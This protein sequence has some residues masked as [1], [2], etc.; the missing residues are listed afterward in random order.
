MN[1]V[2][3][4]EM[5]RYNV[6]IVA[7]RQSLSDMIAAEQGKLQ[8]NASLERASRQI[9]EATVPDQW[10]EKSYPS[11]KPLAA[12]LADLK[13]RVLFL[14]DWF[15]SGTPRVFWISGFY[16]TQSFLTGVLQNYARRRVIPIDEIQFDFH[17]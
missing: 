11:R 3:T 10:M 2:L 4:Q 16:F 12:Y 7:V 5:S 6:L 9:Q 15:E 8:M 17:V 1:T 14:Q 13:R